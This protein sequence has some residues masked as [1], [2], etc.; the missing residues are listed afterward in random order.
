MFEV[1]MKYLKLIISNKLPLLLTYLFPY[2]KYN[3]HKFSERM[4]LTGQANCLNFQ[5]AAK[6][7]L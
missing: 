2:A 1:T 7:S 5:L 6:I 3:W 4:Y